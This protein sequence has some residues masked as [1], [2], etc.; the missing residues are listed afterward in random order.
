VGVFSADSPTT[1]VVQSPDRFLVTCRVVPDTSDA[2]SLL[3]NER[4]ADLVFDR[5]ERACPELFQPAAP[6]TLDFG[7]ARRGYS[8]MRKY[9][10]TDLRVLIIDG[11]VKFIDPLRGGPAIYLGRESDWQKSTLSLSCWRRDERY[12]A[13]L[14]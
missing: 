5:L 12:H 1:R 10:N 9:G 6:I 3:A 13:A 8:W 14:R 11:I 4:E 2:P 7:D